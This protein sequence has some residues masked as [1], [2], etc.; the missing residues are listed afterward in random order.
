MKNAFRFGKRSGDVPN[1]TWK[2]HSSLES[3]LNAVTRLTNSQSHE[4]F[5]AEEENPVVQQPME[6]LRRLMIA[7]RKM[8]S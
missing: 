5:G 8:S 7:S 4:D 6:V 2:I 3:P 1:R